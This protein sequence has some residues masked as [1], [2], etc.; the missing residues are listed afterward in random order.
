MTEEGTIP[1]YIS[2]YKRKRM[3][4]KPNANGYYPVVCYL[5]KEEKTFVF[6]TGNGNLNYGMTSI[7][8]YVME[9]QNKNK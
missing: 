5:S 9:L 7:V 6:K 8:H 4:A 2:T 1:L 3:K